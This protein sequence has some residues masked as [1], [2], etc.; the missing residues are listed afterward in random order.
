MPAA[1]RIES[2]HVFGYSKLINEEYRRDGLRAAS[3]VL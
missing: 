2:F 3:R 1:F